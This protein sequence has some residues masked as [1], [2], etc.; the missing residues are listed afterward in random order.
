MKTSVIWRGE[1]SPAKVWL[2]MVPQGLT[3]GEEQDVKPSVYKK[4]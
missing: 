2:I 4:C 1:R 3:V